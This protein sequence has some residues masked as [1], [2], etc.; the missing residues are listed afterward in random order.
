[1]TRQTALAFPKYR[2]LPVKSKLVLIIMGTVFSTLILACIASLAYGSFAQYSAVKND[3]LV[4]AEIY[5]SNTSAALVFDDPK[6][7]RE[8]LSGLKAKRSIESAVIYASRGQVFAT[9]SRDNSPREVPSFRSVLSNQSQTQRGRI[10]LTRPILSAGSPLGTLYL[11][12]DLNDIYAQVQRSAGVMT[13]ILFA[14]ALLAL[15]LAAKL[16]RVISEPI[17]H[18]TETAM[19][20]STRKDYSARALKVAD[21]DLG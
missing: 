20:V 8:L 16:Q 17:R 2:N 4:L 14:A 3:L 6:A 19:G 1:M 10:R 21:D 9:Y 7:A 5:A 15:L 18:L 13:L 11:Q 12:S